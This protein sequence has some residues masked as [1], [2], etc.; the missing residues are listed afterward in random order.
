MK[1]RRVAAILKAHK[2]FEERSGGL[3]ADAREVGNGDEFERHIRDV[4]QR[5]P[6]IPA[7]AAKPCA[8]RMS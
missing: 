4:H 5:D 8:W 1:N 7:T 3:V 2:K 6:S